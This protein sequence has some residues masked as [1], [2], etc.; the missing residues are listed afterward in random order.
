MAKIPA[1]PATN[2]ALECTNAA[3]TSSIREAIRG[4]LRLHNA[5]PVAPKP[6]SAT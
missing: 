1:R 6:S 2:G 4:R 5:G 3:H